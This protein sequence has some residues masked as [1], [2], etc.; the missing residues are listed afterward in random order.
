MAGGGE[1][2]IVGVTAAATREE[3][4]LVANFEGDVVEGWV[5]EEV[6]RDAAAMVEAMG[7]D[8]MGIVGSEEVLGRTA[9]AGLAWWSAARS[10][11]FALSAGPR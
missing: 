11:P 8:V 3:D 2:T 9:A 7:V 10:R 1:V 4:V 5:R 6:G